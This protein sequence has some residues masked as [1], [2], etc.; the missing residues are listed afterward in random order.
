MSLISR[1]FGGV[2]QP[3]AGHTRKDSPQ[4][5]LRG[6]SSGILGM[7]RAVTR[8]GRH[9]VREAAMRAAALAIDF[10][11]NSGWLAGA[12]DQIICDT[13]GTELKLNCRPD[14]TKLGYD[15]VERR[16]WCRF[17]EG[18]WR[19][20]AWN[21]R[22]CDLA[23]KA[24]VPEM[25][26]GVMRYY[27]GQGE[28]LG[29]FDFIPRAERLAHGFETGTKVRLVSPHRLPFTSAEFTGLDQGIYHDC[30]GRVLS[31]RFKRRENGLELE[32]NIP[33]SSVLHVM[34]RGENPDSPRGIS[35]FAPILK[36]IAQS[37]QLAD[38][39]LATALMQTL[40]A[41]TIKSPE[42]SQEAFQ[43]IQTLADTEMPEGFQGSD[44][45]WSEYVGGIQQ[46]LISV[47]DMRMGS[48]KE[49]G[50]SMSDAARVNHLGPG[51]EFQMHTAATP[52]SQYL[53]F[54][55]NLQR[56]MARRLGVTFESF[57]MDHSNA[58]YSSVRMGI[59]SIWPIVIRRRERIAAPF[60]QG[61][62]EAWLEE[63][64]AEGRIPLKGG[65]RAFL[66]NK[67]R[68]VWAEWQGPARPTADDYKAAMAAK[69]RLE[70]G[71]SSLADECGLEG[72]DWEEN[73]SAIEREIKVLTEKG[74]PHPFGRAQG[75]AGPLGAAAQGNRDPARV[76]D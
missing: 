44:A 30:A 49:R 16:A 29:V 25:L 14:L 68:V 76:D 5:Y 17:V 38:A 23:G 22:E 57:S 46:D 47:I 62:Y 10:V 40:F 54:S 32:D 1:L 70:L 34:D 20:Y 15:D 19:R 55:Q 41:A 24:T 56:E 71:L 2:T 6:D 67:Q 42:P 52:G 51:E 11:Q 13:I 73:A 58:S 12:A 63:G 66:A 33:A 72:K 65:Y 7:R 8:D 3:I 45:D 74:I 39:T 26:D 4:K 28:A 61:I 53:P 75:G 36:V 18:E 9:D 35:I 64:I 50:I 21:P 43:A 59:S 27:L 48:L 60:A 31:Y 69:V 37:D